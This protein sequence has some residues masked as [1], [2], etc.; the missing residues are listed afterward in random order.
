MRI[1]IFDSGL[2]GLVIAKAVIK[3]LPNLDYVYFG[4][5]K[6]LPYGEKSKNQVYNFTR[7]A[8]NFLLEKDCQLVIVACN[9]ASAL[10]LRRLQ[11][12]FLPK[13]YP[14]KKVLG[15]IVPTMENVAENAKIKRLGVLATA[16]TVNS[17]VYKKELAKRTKNVK[18]FEQAAP[19]LV[20][21]IEKG[22]TG[23]IAPMIQR[24]VQPLLAKKVNAIALGCTHYPLVE[25]QI[26]KIA[27]SK[28]EVIN[29][30]KIIPE[31][32]QNYLRRHPEIV[33]ILSK[34]A[35]KEF[36]VTKLNLQFQKSADRLFGGKIN[37]KT[38]K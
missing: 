12:E 6:N 31:S 38:V 17:H 16:F 20:P 18:V 24:Y 4:D 5:T 22:Q 1:G 11:Q 36:F 10:A 33:R 30:T 7:A 34:N 8:V 32:L 27:G 26:K 13:K 29:Q 35:K 25:K 28:V 37:F 3:K 19:K 21:I 15:V 23:K 9:T 2:G 14:D